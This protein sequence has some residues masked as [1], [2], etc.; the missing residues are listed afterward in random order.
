[1]ATDKTAVKALKTGKRVLTGA[2]VILASHNTGKV[3]EFAGLLAPLGVEVLGAGELGL[4]SPTEL[5]ASEGGTFVGN[6]K[7]KAEFACE[8]TGHWALADD[9]GLMVDFLDGGPGVDTAH[10]GG[11]MKILEALEGVSKTAR[12]A[13]FVCVLALA[14]PGK[15]TLTFEGHCRGRIAMTAQGEQG[16]GYDPVFIAENETRTFAEMSAA[17]KSGFSHRA[18]AVKALLEWWNTQRG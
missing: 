6:S 13:E 16:F 1:M 4:E 8:Q 3:L 9:S 10:F 2:E 15:E 14:R 7:L 12:G 5:T 17:E 18:L 11:F